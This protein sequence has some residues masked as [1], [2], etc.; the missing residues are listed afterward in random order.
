MLVLLLFV[1]GCVGVGRTRG[2]R[3]RKE[4]VWRE[5]KCLSCHCC[6]C[7]GESG[8]AGEQGLAMVRH[9]LVFCTVLY[10]GIG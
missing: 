3:T 4:N 7:V 6:G 5:G 9:P 1:R 10:V 8:L 2:Q